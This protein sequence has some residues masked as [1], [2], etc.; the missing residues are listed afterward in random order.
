MKVLF[1]NAC[2]RKESRTL[3]LCRYF[4]EKYFQYHNDVQIEEI[5][6]CEEK[7][8]LP[9][10]EERLTL[11]N[12]LIE[13]KDW[14]QTMMQYANQWKE[15]DAIVIGAPYWD[16]SFPSILKVYIENIFISDLTFAYQE[17]GSVGLCK[18]EKLVYITT[19]GGNAQ[20]NMGFDYIQCVM[21]E[22]GKYQCQYIQASNLDVIGNDVEKI[23]EKTKKEIEEF[24]KNW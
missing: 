7:N 15:A 20:S 5:K 10:N 22:L 23:L 24:V 2:A 19:A 1:V 21:K 8:L 11:R 9:L 4:L 17:N 6:I 16:W 12:Q 3:E 18:G 13:K 14:Q